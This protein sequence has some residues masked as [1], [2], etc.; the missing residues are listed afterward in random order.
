VACS[1]D[2]KQHHVEGSE[3]KKLMKKKLKIK[4]KKR[5]KNK[6][7]KHQKTVKGSLSSA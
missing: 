3:N 6:N 2:R 1:N 7:D 4:Q 5:N